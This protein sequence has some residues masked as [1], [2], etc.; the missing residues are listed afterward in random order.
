M[1]VLHVMGGF[2]I[3]SSRLCVTQAGPA[4]RPSGCLCQMFSSFRRKRS[5]SDVSYVTYTGLL[6]DIN[7]PSS[8][9]KCPPRLDLS[10]FLSFFL[11][12]LSSAV[13]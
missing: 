3:V 12:F 8:Y 2:I 10:F 9:V 13:V 6:G 1:C 11:S 4:V 5:N 7:H